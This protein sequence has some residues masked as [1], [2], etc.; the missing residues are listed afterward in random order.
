MVF[1]C[2]LHNISLRV[3]SEHANVEKIGTFFWLFLA[4]FVTLLENVA[5]WGGGDCVYFLKSAQQGIQTE[6]GPTVYLTD[7]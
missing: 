2:H 3:P 7:M 1:H 4:L 6:S 5:P